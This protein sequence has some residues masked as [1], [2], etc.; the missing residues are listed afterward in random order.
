MHT[1][2]LGMLAE[3]PWEYSMMGKASLNART[4]MTGHICWCLAVQKHVGLTVFVA[5]TY[6][7]ESDPCMLAR[8]WIT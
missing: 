6:V 1:P 3:E 5:G 2:L 4:H 8:S 7:V